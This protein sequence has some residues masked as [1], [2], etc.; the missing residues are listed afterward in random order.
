[1]TEDRLPGQIRLDSNLGP[2]N[3]TRY[4]KTSCEWAGGGLVSTTV[5][6]A[7][8]NLELFSQSATLRLTIGSA[9]NQSLA[10]TYLEGPIATSSMGRRSTAMARSM[11]PSWP[12]DPKRASRSR[13]TSLRR[14]SPMM[15][16]RW[17]RPS[18]RWWERPGSSVAGEMPGGERAQLFE[19]VHLGSPAGGAGLFP[20]EGGHS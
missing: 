19:T 12:N 1:M 5:E 16:N 18:W 4:I 20:P 17:L 15:P 11:D 3:M 2:L 14:R 8:F 6:V 10:E 13:P 7:L 9:A